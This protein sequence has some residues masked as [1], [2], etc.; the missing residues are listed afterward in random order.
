MAK[1]HIK[2]CLPSLI[3]VIEMQIKTTV[4]Y[5]FTLSEWPSSKNLQTTN[6]GEHVEKREP[7][8]TVDG[9][10]TATMENTTEV[11]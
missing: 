9:N 10:V 5:L 1:R 2:R 6:A 8:C 4:R 7:S 11:P 3:I